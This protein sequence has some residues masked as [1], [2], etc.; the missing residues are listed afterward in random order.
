MNSICEELFNSMKKILSTCNI[1][2]LP[3][4]MILLSGPIDIWAGNV[5]DFQ[6]NWGD[7]FWTFL[8]L[9]VL[10]TIIVT[11]I[12]YKMPD[13]F[14]KPVETILFAGSICMYIQAMFMNVVLSSEDGGHM[15][16]ENYRSLTWGTLIVWVLVFLLIIVLFI[17]K[18]AITLKMMDYVSLFSNII[19]GIAVIAI[20]FMNLNAAGY[21]SEMYWFNGDDQYKVASGNNIIVVVLDSFGSTQLDIALE[22]DANLLEPLKDF[23][24][25]DNTNPVYYRTF[26]SETH[27]LTGVEYDTNMTYRG[28]LDYAWNIEN[29][30]NYYNKLHEN[31]YNCYLHADSMD[32]VFN[33]G[34]NLVDKFDNIKMDKGAIYDH[35]ALAR[36]MLKISLYRY[37][38][39]LLKP[40]FEVLTNEFPP[41]MKFEG[42]QASDTSMA[43][44]KANLEKNGI[45]IGLES[46]NALI[47][48]SLNGTHVPLRLNENA[49][50]VD[51][52]DTDIGRE[53]RGVMLIV[54]EYLD[55][56]KKIGKY[57]DSTI[58]LMAD[59][60]QWEV[61]ER[62][63]LQTIFFL[64]KSNE[65]HDEI[66][67]SS[68]P[69]SNCDLLATIY[70]AARLD[71]SEYGT[72]VTD[73]QDGDER[74]RTLYFVDDGELRGWI[75]NSEEELYEKVKEE[76]DI[77]V[78]IV[79]R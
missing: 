33:N 10:I 53:V 18:K 59:H 14:S 63:D 77:H 35:A 3:F 28:W 23:T 24:Y 6:F 43:G 62:Q 51:E 36:K 25:Y 61:E 42:M 72:S 41:L 11:F 55:Y 60:A 71:Y 48:Q 46:E 2:M 56:L 13:K 22:Q 76:P 67:I 68:A 12:L 37:L 47:I 27:F 5:K 54:Y 29:T 17:K 15:K 4:M 39:Y 34:N 70:E 20:I 8:I 64:K 45:E 30:C 21:V 40:R 58:I 49:E 1:V 57:E 32:Y 50:V 9:F 79:I 69:I 73:W 66:N 52:T 16:W 65:S 78:D 75:Y 26:P 44:F 19:Q 38:P 74:E 31:G 7:F